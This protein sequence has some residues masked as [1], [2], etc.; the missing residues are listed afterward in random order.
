MSRSNRDKWQFIK[1][2]IR[3]ALSV[4][5][6]NYWK[7]N[8]WKILKVGIELEF[9]LPEAGGG[10][11]QQN[12]ACVCIKF[13]SKNVCW[14]KCALVNTCKRL[15]EG[16]E[17]LD[18]NC[19]SF[20]SA[21]LICSHFETPCKNC[22]Y[23]FDPNRDPD[24]LRNNITA[25]LNPSNSYGNITKDGVHSVIGDGSLLGGTK[26]NKGV[27]VITVG[28]RVD[29][30]EFYKMSKSILDT[31]TKNGAWLNER[32][33]IHM[34]LLTSYYNSDRAGFI[35][36]MEK[37]MPEIIAANFH[38]LVRRYQNAL[39]WM[40]LGLDNPNN[41][42]RWERYRVSIMNISAVKNRMHDVKQLTYE[43]SGGNKYSFANYTNMMFGNNGD[44]STF[45]VELRYMDGIISPS[46]VAAIACLNHALVIK[47]TEI[48]RYGLLKMPDKE[49]FAEAK[50][51]KKYILNNMKSYDAGD[52]FGHTQ[53]VIENKDYYIR[54]SLGLVQQ[55]KHILLR[56][57]PAYEV[58]EKL[59]EMPVA[60]MR[61]DG[62]SW[63]QIE[64]KM[65]VAMVDEN[66]LNAAIHEY[67]DLR[68]IDNVA[69]SKS[70]SKKLRVVCGK[71]KT[72]AVFLKVTM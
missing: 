6:V 36:E 35:N 24:Q 62:D 58:L 56:T 41:L 67:I 11:K 48:S 30:W 13:N 2:P 20:V 54:E 44:V 8:L 59:A 49:W 31:A 25:D 33:S 50:T 1:H 46:I 69:P 22:N 70:G 18:E 19:N 16:K 4:Q 55:L 47:A 21:C 66:V 9:N 3:D 71:I 45:H 40:T 34:H 38:Q 15:K 32:C 7:A 68:L 57:G 29:Y 72:T 12:P 42:T 37:D 43:H 51:M 65:K 39:V 61:I 26:K 5:A 53:H 52:R 64:D 27:E 60:L 17:C 14:Q 28:R 10:C 63:D 23:K